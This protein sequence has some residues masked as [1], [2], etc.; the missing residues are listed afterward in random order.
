MMLTQYAPIGR[1]NC[2]ACGE[3][4]FT[5]PYDAE[6]AGQK[7]T[8]HVCNPYRVPVT[9]LTQGQLETIVELAVTAVLRRHGIIKQEGER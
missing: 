9:S 5:T 6:A 7:W 1:H 4:S 2:A 8:P 3:Q